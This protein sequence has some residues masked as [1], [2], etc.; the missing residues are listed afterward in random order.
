MGTIRIHFTHYNAYIFANFAQSF[1]LHSTS[2]NS[3]DLLRKPHVWTSW[4]RMDELT[5][6]PISVPKMGPISTIEFEITTIQTSHQTMTQQIAYK[7]ISTLDITSPGRSTFTIYPMQETYGA[8]GNREN[9]SY[10]TAHYASSVRSRP[11]KL[12]ARRL[13]SYTFAYD[14]HLGVLD[15]PN[16]NSS[17]C[18]ELRMISSWTSWQSALSAGFIKPAIKSRKF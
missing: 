17:K 3:W 5:S 8:C 14:I 6:T 16:W 18:W 13:P 11:R 12:K 1:T 15:C 4:P 7:K 10:Y 2:W 9:I